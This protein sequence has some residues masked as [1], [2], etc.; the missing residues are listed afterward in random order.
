MF[1]YGR[2][3]G[4]IRVGISADGGDLGGYLCSGGVLARDSGGDLGWSFGGKSGENGWGF[5]FGQGLG[6]RFAFGW[7]FSQRFGLN[8]GR[9]GRDLGLSQ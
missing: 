4:K 1:G 6:L 8:S 2:R 5:A 3:F 9:G 7:G